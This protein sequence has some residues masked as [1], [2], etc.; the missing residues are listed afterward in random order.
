MELRLMA[1]PAWNNSENLVFTDPL[2]SHL[3]HDLIYR[4][5]KRIFAQLGVP[6]LRFHDLRHPNV[7]PATKEI[8]IYKKQK[9]QIIE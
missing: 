9:L 1:G 7:K 2:G 5:L 8:F 6:S 3:K 4:H